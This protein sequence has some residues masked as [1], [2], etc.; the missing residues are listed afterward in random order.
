MAR[1]SRAGKRAQGKC[2]WL[3]QYLSGQLATGTGVGTLLPKLGGLPL[4]LVQ[5]DSYARDH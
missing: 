5:A 2:I 4:A 1:E 3:V